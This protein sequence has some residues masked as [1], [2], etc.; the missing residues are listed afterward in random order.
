M[1]LED[2]L[3]CFFGNVDNFVCF[4]GKVCMLE[5]V[6]MCMVAQIDVEWASRRRL[7]DAFRC[8]E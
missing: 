7:R 2:F 6:G 4:G 3:G 5:L 8:R 1:V